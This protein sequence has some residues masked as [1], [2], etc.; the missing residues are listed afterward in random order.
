M[1]HRKTTNTQKAISEEPLF[2]L[3]LVELDRH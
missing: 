1:K 3:Q 2:K